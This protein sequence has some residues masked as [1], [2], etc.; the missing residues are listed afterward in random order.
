MSPAAPSSA[1]RGT[2]PR[3]Q[4]KGGPIPKLDEKD[5]RQHVMAQLAWMMGSTAKSITKSYVSVVQASDMTIEMAWPLVKVIAERMHAEGLVY[6]TPQ[7]DDLFLLL[8]K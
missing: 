7:D 3:Q 1:N 5:V 2:C 6:A 8:R 4:E